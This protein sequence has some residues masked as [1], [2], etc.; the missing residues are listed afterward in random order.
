MM[1]DVSTWQLD[2][3]MRTLSI[4]WPGCKSNLTTI[5][6]GKINW[7]APFGE[8]LQPGRPA[9]QSSKTI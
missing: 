5:P 2:I 6:F 4:N 9:A 3:Y 1:I 7:V 8:F